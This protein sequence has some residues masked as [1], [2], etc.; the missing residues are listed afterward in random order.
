M[1]SGHHRLGGKIGRVT[2]ITLVRHGQTDWNL[3]RR[4]QGLTDIP[5]NDTGRAQARSAALALTVALDDGA[6]PVFASST[7]SRAIETAEIMG[8]RFD[9]APPRTYDDLRER[10]Y[11]EAEGVTD[12]EMFER[13]GPWPIADVPGA[14]Q[15]GALR[16]RALRGITAAVMDAGVAGDEAARL[17]I[18]AHG[19]VIREVIRAA[20]EDTLPLPD[21]RLENGSLHTVR[22]T[23]AGTLTLVEYDPVALAA[24]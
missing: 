10:N 19:G 7:L 4:I 6:R 12:I 15:Q 2:L 8:T 5:L 11:G 24:R 16:E 17:V 18:V 9:A 22:L 1:R 20:T 23:G 13:W 3:A 21:E 14:E